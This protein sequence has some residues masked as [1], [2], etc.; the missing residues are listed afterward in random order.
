MARTKRT[1]LGEYL[2]PTRGRSPQGSEAGLPS[3][4][5]PPSPSR[6]VVG[7][8]S[9]RS[10]PD[11]TKHDAFSPPRPGDHAEDGQS[12]LW[13]PGLPRRF[14]TMASCT[15]SPLELRRAQAERGITDQAA[16]AARRERGPAVYLPP[17]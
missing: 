15:S 16:F 11:K 5:P 6:P 2:L 13:P 3:S 12:G 9:P 14:S 17:G 7:L 4:P 1:P 10:T 8:L